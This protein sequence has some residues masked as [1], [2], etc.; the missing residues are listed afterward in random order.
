MGEK[1]FEADLVTEEARFPWK[2]GWR[3]PADVID[4]GVMSK[5]IFDLMAAN[6]HK[7]EEAMIAGVGTVEALKKVIGSL[8]TTT[9][10][11]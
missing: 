8:V 6:E 7:A 3:P 11:V 2:E 5:T 1:T 9:N 4:Q 10:Y